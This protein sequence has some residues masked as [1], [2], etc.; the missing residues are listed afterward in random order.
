MTAVEPTDNC[1]GATTRGVDLAAP[2]GEHDL[3]RSSS[4]LG[5]AGASVFRFLSNI[6]GNG[7]NRFRRRGNIGLI[8][9]VSGYKTFRAK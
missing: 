2:L 7:R 1:V 3:G 9:Q 6:A 5:A 4:R 8:C